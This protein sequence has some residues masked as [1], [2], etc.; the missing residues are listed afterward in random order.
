MKRIL[1]YITCNLII[2]W[3]LFWS[4]Y[5]QGGGDILASGIT[6]CISIIYFLITFFIVSD[7]KVIIQVG[8]GLI[9]GLILNQI[10]LNIFAYYR[11]LDF[12]KT[13]PYYDSPYSSIDS[14][15]FFYIQKNIEELK[16]SEINF[17]K[18]TDL[19]FC[20]ETDVQILPKYCLKFKNLES[21]TLAA[22]PNLQIDS[23]MEIISQITTIKNLDLTN[24][25]LTHI[26]H[27]IKK[28]TSLEK[29]DLSMNPNLNIDSV[30][31]IV[32][33]MKTLTSV[34]W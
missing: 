21:L 29:L 13:H 10:S 3:L 20:L 30:K 14:T 18:I 26:P 1:I 34:T 24:C 6:F 28:L 15:R 22:N 5:G 7:K 17:E 2:F 27:S 12:M 19:S 31:Q 33:E 11:H 23:T 4:S 32:S 16:E 9:L 8:I 25:N